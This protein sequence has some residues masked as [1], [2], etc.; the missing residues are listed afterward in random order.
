MNDPHSYPRVDHQTPELRYSSEESTSNC[1]NTI[2]WAFDEFQATKRGIQNRVYQ[3][4]ALFNPGVIERDRHLLPSRGLEV[5]NFEPPTSGHPSAVG[6]LS[7]VEPALTPVT[8]L[9]S[10]LSLEL[11][12][13]PSSR[14]LLPRSDHPSAP[15]SQNVQHSDSSSFLLHTPRVMFGSP[16]SEPEIS[17]VQPCPPFCRSSNMYCYGNPSQEDVARLVSELP[18]DPEHS[19]QLSNNLQHPPSCPILIE[20]ASNIANEHG[21]HIARNPLQLVEGAGGKTS[22][23]RQ[24]HLSSV[25]NDMQYC[26]PQY[27]WAQYY[28]QKMFDTGSPFRTLFGSSSFHE[29]NNGIRHNG[30]SFHNSSDNGRLQDTTKDSDGVKT[31]SSSPG[32]LTRILEQL[33]NPSIGRSESEKSDQPYHQCAVSRGVPLGPSDMAARQDNDVQF[34]PTLADIRR[35]SC[36]KEQ[37]HACQRLN[38]PPKV[39]NREAPGFQSIYYSLQPTA[40]VPITEHSAPTLPSQ[41]TQFHEVRGNDSSNQIKQS[42]KASER[43][44]ESQLDTTSAVGHDRE[45]Q[46]MLPVVHRRVRNYNPFFEVCFFESKPAHDVA[47]HS[48][49]STGDRSTSQTSEQQ[50][51][52]LFSGCVS[53]TSQHPCIHGT[54]RRAAKG[55]RTVIVRPQ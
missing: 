40:D 50:R 22:Q 6:F 25:D 4:M 7:L 17:S 36:N 14:A 26:I 5:C 27:N 37:R 48:L 38:L 47:A 13:L 12:S 44:I 18:S 41:P 55:A 39:P 49:P 31:N 29:G 28:D 2:S 24:T 1:S 20:R 45:I 9:A 54:G 52:A 8:E 30:T 53:R 16:F 51:K 15:R 35:L 23:M 10:S 33:F 42:D 11:N 3:D 43:Q 46:Q 19:T 21:G 32:S 34:N